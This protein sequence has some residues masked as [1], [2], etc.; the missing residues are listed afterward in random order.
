ML[1]LLRVHR[2]LPYRIGTII[3][4]NVLEM[5]HEE[6]YVQ[7]TLG[8]ESVELLIRR[9]DMGAIGAAPAT[10]GNSHAMKPSTGF[11]AC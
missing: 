9:F 5:E 6:F 8:Q 2:D 3:P 10:G 1:A 7:L 4:K 11:P